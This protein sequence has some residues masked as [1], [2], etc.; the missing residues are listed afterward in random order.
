[1][2]WNFAVSNVFTSLILVTTAAHFTAQEP[3]ASATQRSRDQLDDLSNWVDTVRNTNVSG[4]MARRIRNAERLISK[5]WP[6]AK[7]HVLDLLTNTDQSNSCVPVC[8]AIASRPPDHRE[9]V[10]KLILLLDDVNSTVRHEAAIALARFEN[11]D[12]VDR[13]LLISQD[14]NAS[15]RMRVAALQAIS[16][17]N[18]SRRAVRTLIELLATRDGHIDDD[19]YSALSRAAGIDH[20]RRP[21]QWYAWWQQ[22]ESLSDEQWLKR[23]IDGLRKQSEQRDATIVDLESRLVDA[24]T[25]RY[26]L[27]P[28]GERIK[29]LV[30][31]LGDEL[32]A[33]KGLALDLVMLDIGEGLQ[34]N[35]DVLALVRERLSDDSPSVRKGVLNILGH[36]RDPNDATAVIAVLESENNQTV[37]LT[38][39]ETLG[40]LSSAESVPA[41]V[42]E[43]TNAECLNCRIA[44]ARSLGP[45]C[46]RNDI[47]SEVLDQVVEGLIAQYE[48]SA[49]FEA[50]RIA[51]LTA[52]SEMRDARFSPMLLANLNDAK[53]E[54]RLRCVTGLWLRG[55]SEH[56]NRVLPM[57]Q[58]TD[59]AVRL[60]AARAIGELG[61]DDHLDVLLTRLDREVEP[62]DAVREAVWT[63][64]RLLWAK[65][66]ADQRF[67]MAAKFDKF[68]TYETTLL[69][70][71]HGDPQL[72]GD[73]TL[74]TNV[75]RRLAEVYDQRRMF[76]KAAA[77]WQSVV[78]A[79]I[80]ANDDQAPQARLRLFGSLIRA[81]DDDAA[82]KTLRELVDD[83][84]SVFLPEL[85][86][87]VIAYLQE[88]D[89][90]DSAIRSCNVLQWLRD[91]PGIIDDAFTRR[92][93]AYATRC[94]ANAG[95]QPST[96][97]TQ[98]NG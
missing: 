23:T 90:T 13:L 92:L 38:A 7:T 29:L 95:S 94:A 82:G 86:N 67:A 77:R 59:A 37:R 44:A 58:D 62:E 84:A 4:G 42:S 12:L 5:E 19:L 80:A 31:F 21:D 64:Y 46:T 3:E 14:T 63:S 85:R 79:M 48:A 71:L 11:P 89:T 27:T 61:N 57:L 16:Q 60:T 76:D 69:E 28:N 97:G 39:I 73:G 74:N 93:A 36:L 83:D 8:R 22:C 6:E 68:P 24:Q 40:R 34:P 32:D 10:P 15:K 1:M 51:V 65:L 54:V 70:Q 18:D 20:G 75:I 2:T 98:N 91:A 50:L 45:L 78:D 47:G 56:L 96:S 55:N 17:I 87:E 41:L 30:H 33:I 43:L 88:L 66:S 53:A 72:N 9:F 52:M 35:D 49:E 25:A 26:H 81:E